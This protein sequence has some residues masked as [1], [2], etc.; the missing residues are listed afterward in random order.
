M[1]IRAPCMRQMSTRGFV[2]I[3]TITNLGLTGTNKNAH[4]NQG[5]W[6]KNKWSKKDTSNCNSAYASWDG[7]IYPSK[8]FYLFNRVINWSNHS[9]SFDNNLENAG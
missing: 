2:A 9:S 6:P 8:P 7:S 5:S 3:D 4:R 1:V